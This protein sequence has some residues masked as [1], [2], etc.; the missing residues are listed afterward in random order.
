MLLFT[1]EW[2]D[3]Y[4]SP[5]DKVDGNLILSVDEVRAVGNLVQNKKFLIDQPTYLLTNFTDTGSVFITPEVATPTIYNPAANTEVKGAFDIET[6]PML[7]YH[8]GIWNQNI[9]TDDIVKHWSILCFSAKWLIEDEIK[10]RRK[11]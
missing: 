2:D 4:Q 10:R 5:L 9:N 6:S 1:F 3:A 11:Q 8:W 7:S